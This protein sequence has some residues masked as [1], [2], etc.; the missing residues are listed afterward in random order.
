[1]MI[2]RLLAA[3]LAL[4]LLVPAFA[5]AEETAAAETSAPEATAAPETAAE[6]TGAI[7]TAEE[8][9]VIGG[10]GEAV[11]GV[12]TKATPCPV[13]M[14]GQKDVFGESGKPDELRAEYG[15]TAD[16]IIAA[17]KGLL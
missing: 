9:S 2:K 8:H 10:L 12:V 13:R 5:A 17:V 4:C 1:M 6:E 11:A 16:D 14:I 3:L 7:V 15:M